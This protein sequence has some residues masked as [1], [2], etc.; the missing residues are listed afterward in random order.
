MN[1]R[2]TLADLKAAGGSVQSTERVP[3]DTSLARF[4]KQTKGAISVPGIGTI[5]RK[6][7]KTL[8]LET[9]VP[10]R[11]ELPLTDLD[12]ALSTPAVVLMV[13]RIFGNDPSLEI[14]SVRER[15][16]SLTPREAQVLDLMAA[17]R[18]NRKIAEQLAISPKTL[19]IHRANIQRK[20]GVKGMANPVRQRLFFAI[21]EALMP[22]IATAGGEDRA[23]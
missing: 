5:R 12:Q 9:S 14:D 4:L 22:E 13:Q 17:G 15:L 11:A 18:N 2:D 7:S 16:R 3:D 23:D 10:V 20:L 8:T 1:I 6:D 21:C 19:D